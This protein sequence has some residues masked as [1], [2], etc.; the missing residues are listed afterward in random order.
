MPRRRPKWLALVLAGAALAAPLRAASAQT[1]G[2]REA[3]ALTLEGVLRRA[4]ADAE[5]PRIAEARLEQAEAAVRMAWAA[6][7][8]QL[9][10]SGTYRR[11][12]FEVS[13]PRELPD[14]RTER[15]VF[16]ALDAF[17]GEAR[18][19]S[20]LFEARALPDIGAAEQDASAAR[21]AVE[22]SRFLLAHEVAEA[23]VGV[24][25]AEGAWSAATRRLEVARLDASAAAERAGAG[26]SAQSE[27]DRAE[28]ES[29]EAE[30]AVAQA[31]EAARRARIA[32][33]L[34][35]GSPIS[36]PLL[37]VQAEA[38]AA[39]DLGEAALLARPELK[40]ARAE[41]AAAEDRALAPWLALAPTLTLD[42]LATATNE[43]GF[44][45]RV[46][47]W[48]VALTLSWA[49]Y[50]GGR[51]YA[52]A[53]STAA[54]V[55]A[56]RLELQFAERQVQ[57][58]L[59]EARAGLDAATTERTLAARRA[60]VASRYESEIRAR[61]ARGLATAVEAADAAAVRFAAE[62]GAATADAMYA[63]ALIRLRRAAG[64][65]PAEIST[66][67]EGA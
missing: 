41:V 11:R 2:G 44:L 46:F 20:T 52:E 1:G 5:S 3:G 62:V 58:E 49:L 16:Q 36:E 9:G 43:T 65:L 57:S 4:L 31:E 19:S 15:A 59:E 54:G 55:D 27:A 13:V 10:V 24:L 53:R 61:A 23:Y 35:A 32:L 12:A 45:G 66:N 34:L 30:L 60:K 18:L 50:D 38:P 29:V 40:V 17:F 37:P 39:A 26:L 47:N 42:G 8:P 33:G 67:S 6:L 28:L 56:A 22:R 14:G 63:R 25:L 64:S 48:N 21:A 7:L 51:R